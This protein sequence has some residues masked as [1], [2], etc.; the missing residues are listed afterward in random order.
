MDVPRGL[1]HRGG[2]TGGTRRSG[3]RK[4]VLFEERQHSSGRL[5]VQKGSEEQRNGG[6]LRAVF[7]RASRVADR[8]RFM[9]RQRALGWGPLGSRWSLDS[10]PAVSLSRSL[11]GRR[12]A[13]GP[14]DPM[15]SV[16]RS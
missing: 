3:G 10:A 14:G 7:Q 1:G 13:M 11:P 6:T 5:E 9:R 12:I 4:G 16:A 2:I 8:I 15:R